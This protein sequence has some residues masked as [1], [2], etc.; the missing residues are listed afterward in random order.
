[1]LENHAPA[2]ADSGTAVKRY[3]PPNQRNRALNRRKSGDRFDRPS[4]GNDGEKNYPIT[5]RSLPV[6]DH[7]DAGSSTFLN[8][9]P[10]TRLIALDGCCRSEGSQL[11]TERW[12]AALHLYNN[13]SIDLSE[14]PVMY[15]GSNASAW[16]HIRLP[17]QMM[18][19]SNSVGPS[20]GSQ[21][22]FLSELR[23]AMRNS[24]AS[25]DN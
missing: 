11:L 13:T 15:S 5:S 12:A 16:G 17:H 1:M 7:G 4:Y 21:M 3:A 8:E 2:A 24:S 19:S 23:R 6:L 25:S 18:S 20:S 10:R 14:R 22:D 9:N